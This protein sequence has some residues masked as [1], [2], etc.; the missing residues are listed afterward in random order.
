MFFIV[1]V[2][3]T[4]KRLAVTNS[5]TQATRYIQTLPGHAL[6]IYYIDACSEPVMLNELSP[7]D[8]PPDLREGD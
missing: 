2:T 8:L 1:G 7:D 4:C 3:D 5:A 6:G